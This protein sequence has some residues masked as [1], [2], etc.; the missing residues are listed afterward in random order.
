M[1]TIFELREEMD[2]LDALDQGEKGTIVETVV[3]TL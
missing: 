3:N 1:F 2:K